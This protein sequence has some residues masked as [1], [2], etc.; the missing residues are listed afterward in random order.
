M[1]R[2]VLREWIKS[3]IPFIK[4]MLY[5]AVF[6]RKS[7]NKPTFKQAQELPKIVSALE[8]WGNRNG[9]MAVIAAIEGKQVGAAWFR[10]WDESNQ[11]TGYINEHIPVIAVGVAG[12]HRNKA[13]GT[14]MMKYLIHYAHSNSIT[15]V[16]LAVSKDNYALRLYKKL[17][18]KEYE[19]KGDWFI[20]VRNT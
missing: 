18:F 9:D 6:W 8:N 3:D 19:D 17:G 7:E 11:V 14:K 13:I 12:E 5:E 20:M 15:K 2:L 10:Y 16:S 1:D 4:E